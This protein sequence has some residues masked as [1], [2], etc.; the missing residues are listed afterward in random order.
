MKIL[1][2]IDEMTFYHP[3]FLWNLI[4]KLKKK[5]FKIE[6]ALVTKILKKSN[7]E[8]Y[9]LRNLNKL[10]LYEIFLLSLKRILFPIVDLITRYIDIYYSVESVLKVN[11]IKF[12]K[13]K[14]DI[15]KE[16]YLNRIIKYEP[17]LIISS[18]SAIF[19]EKLLSIPKLGCINRHSS[20]LPSYGGLCPIFHSISQG[21]KTLGVTIHKMESKIDTG[22]ILA[23]RIV[24][25]KDNNLSEI[26]KKCFDVSS[27]LVIEAIDNLIN[28]KFLKN[29]YQESYFSFPNEKQWEMFRKNNGKFI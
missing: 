3:I 18:C 23:Q 7:L 8:K 11:K 19:K 4:K 15:N 22:Q 13:V 12:F 9:L 28:K 27:D 25:N 5:N 29:N 20:L 26:Y 1:I 24:E 6:V 21:Q 14:L 16:E 2:A 10:T 17:D